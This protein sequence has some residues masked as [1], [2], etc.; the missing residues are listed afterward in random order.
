MVQPRLNW[1]EKTETSTFPV[2]KHAPLFHPHLCITYLPANFPC[3]ISLSKCSSL[4]PNPASVFACHDLK[5]GRRE[6]YQR[7]KPL[8]TNLA[9]HQRVSPPTEATSLNCLCLHQLK[10]KKVPPPDETVLTFFMSK[11]RHAICFSLTISSCCLTSGETFTSLLP[12][13]EEK[14]GEAVSRGARV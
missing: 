10:E 14:T 12:S 7:A 9:L 1:S 4:S 5:A 2:S 11:R 8:P 3:I 6:P 13:C